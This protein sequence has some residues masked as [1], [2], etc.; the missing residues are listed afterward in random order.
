M[1]SENLKTRRIQKN[2][3]QTELAERLYVSRQTISKWERGISVPD[4]DLIIKIAGILDTSVSTLL[5]ENITIDEEVDNMEM[6]ANK[7][8]TLNYTLAERNHRNKRL[9]HVIK[10]LFISMI[11]ITIIYIMIGVISFQQ[12][13][14]KTE[15]TQEELIKP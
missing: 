7:L 1:L 4:A 14:V 9:W 5:G 13:D 10:I 6:I 12:Y 3:S 2:I 8:E 11:V 15:I